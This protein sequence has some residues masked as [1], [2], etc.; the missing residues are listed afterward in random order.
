MLKSNFD[1]SF[2]NKIRRARQGDVA[3]LIARLVEADPELIPTPDQDPD[4]TTDIFQRRKNQGAG[5]HARP[6]GERLV[7]HPALIGANRDLLSAALLQKIHVRA[8][9]RKKLMATNRRTKSAHV[10]VFEVIDR[11][12]DMRHPAVHKMRRNL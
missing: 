8:F 2:E 4:R 9:W 11:H 1:R 7:F 3:K 5:Y 10:H 6:A 12:D